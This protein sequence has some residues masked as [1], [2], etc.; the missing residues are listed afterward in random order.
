ML[1]IERSI[2]ARKIARPPLLA[3]PRA[4]PCRPH[5]VP[6]H[7]RHCNKSPTYYENALLRK[8]VSF[9]V[10]PT[11]FQQL[12]SWCFIMYRSN[13]A[14]NWNIFSLFDETLFLYMVKQLKKDKKKHWFIRCSKMFHEWWFCCVST[15]K[16]IEIFF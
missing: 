2:S 1:A 9:F 16:T 6:H 4:P 15:F 5:H 13:V 8:S 14:V 10:P 7:I 11:M 12:Y 3:P